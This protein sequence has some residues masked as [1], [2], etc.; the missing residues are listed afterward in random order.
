MSI[1]KVRDFALFDTEQSGNLALSQLAGLQNSQHLDS[2]LS[3]CQKL[4][5]ILQAYVSKDVARATGGILIFPIF[6]RACARSCAAC[7]R[8]HI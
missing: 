2:D 6:L 1:H 5:G 7:K 4:I 8:N 3:A